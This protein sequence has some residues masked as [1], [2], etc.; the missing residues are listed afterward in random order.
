MAR[1]SGGLGKGLSS[2]IPPGEAAG[3]AGPDDGSAVL[4]DIPVADITPNPNQ[5]STIGST[6]THR[7]VSPTANC[8]RFNFS[9]NHTPV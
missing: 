4:Q 9:A 1:P 7:N 2:L 8:G 5:Q 3:G 6:Q